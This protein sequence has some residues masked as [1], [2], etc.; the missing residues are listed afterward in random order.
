[1]SNLFKH[2]GHTSC[3]FY[4]TDINPHAAQIAA[5]TLR[6]N[7]VSGDIIRSHFTSCFGDRLHHRVDVLIFNP[8][9]VPSPESELGRTD[10]IAALSGGEDGRVVTD[11]FLPCV[12]V[13]EDDV[14]IDD[15]HQ[16]S[17]L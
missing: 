9:Y 1:M 15:F 3:E 13:R 8:P 5:E 6:R 7:K 2:A 14:S 11:E 4:G 12:D 10:L 16:S 17:L